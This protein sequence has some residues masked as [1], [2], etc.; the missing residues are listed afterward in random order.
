MV[1]AMGGPVRFVEDWTRFLPEAPVI[2]EV[3]APATGTI[4]AIQGEALGLA[5]V[6]LGGGRQVES[7]IVN[8]AV[9]LSDVVALG[10]K[11]TKGQPLAR[12]HAAREAQA[13][14]AVQ[15]V[16][17]AITIGGQAPTPNLVLETIT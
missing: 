13:D 8:P 7:D 6:A 1:Y 10:D 16:Q 15:A 12:V 14:A 4:S 11:V 5:V 2:R 17:S 3:P 9:G